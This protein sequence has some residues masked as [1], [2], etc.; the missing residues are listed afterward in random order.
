M[1]DSLIDSIASGGWF[2]ERLMND[3]HETMFHYTAH[4]LEADAT[5]PKQQQKVPKPKKRVVSTE[6]TGF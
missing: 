2:C 4:D 6:F 5:S 1:I 3:H